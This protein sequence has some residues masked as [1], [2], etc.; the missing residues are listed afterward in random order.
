LLS[1]S[2]RMDNGIDAYVNGRWR[3]CYECA[4]SWMGLPVHACLQVFFIGRRAK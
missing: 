4:N 2:M 1:R 3:R